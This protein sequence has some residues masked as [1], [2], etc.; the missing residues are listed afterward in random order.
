[1]MIIPAIDLIQGQCVRLQ[2]GDYQLKTVYPQ[3][4]IERIQAFESA[5]FRYC[6]IVDLEGAKNPD[7]NQHE[8][9]SDL[10][11]ASQIRIQ[12]GG[13]IRDRAGI[14]RLLNAGVDRIVIGSLAVK[15]PELVQQWIE[16]LGADKIVLALD[17]RWNGL[18]PMVLTSAW[19]EESS[20]SL[21]AL[22]DRYPS[23]EHVLCTDIACDGMLQG[24]NLE[25][26]QQAITRFPNLSWQA[27]GGIRDQSDVTALQQLGISAAIVGKAL[28][29]REF[30]PC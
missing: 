7:K 13:G 23:I 28:Y 10:V 24:P 9:I 25:L 12:V 14:D 6:H 8:L 17:I 29:Q 2:Q 4:P 11:Q 19:Q 22:L 20:Q 16:D 18:T 21:W 27:S 1:M 15:Q 3:K 5:G 26:Y 30:T